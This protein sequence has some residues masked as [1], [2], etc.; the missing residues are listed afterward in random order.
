[1]I[2]YFAQLVTTAGT[3]NKRLEIY[4]IEYFP[5]KK[6][7]NKFMIKNITCLNKKLACEPDKLHLPSD[8]LNEKLYPELF[9]VKKHIIKNFLADKSFSIKGVVFND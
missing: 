2:G 1:M 3:H 6:Q 4:K 9:D 7:K 5:V 8:N